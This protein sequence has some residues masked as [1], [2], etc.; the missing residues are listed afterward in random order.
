MSPCGISAA[1]LACRPPPPPALP[2]HRHALSAWPRLAS[3]KTPAHA[4]AGTTGSLTERGLRSR[5]VDAMN[6]CLVVYLQRHPRQTHGA[7]PLSLAAHRWHT[8][9][10]LHRATHPRSPTAHP[11]ASHPIPSTLTDGPAECGQ[12]GV[13]SA[14]GEFDHVRRQHLRHAPHRR[15]H[16]QQPRTRGLRHCHAEGLSKRRV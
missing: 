9:Y 14:R 3:S 8:P 1:S 13:R 7:I 10:A 12:E 15:A 16:D 5:E 6:G 2:R 11:R 4:R